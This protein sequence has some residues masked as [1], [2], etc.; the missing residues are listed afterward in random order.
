MLSSSAS[1]HG[2][3]A[4]KKLIGAPGV[5]VRYYNIIYDAVDE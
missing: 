3:Y 2:P 1:T 4:S 5:D